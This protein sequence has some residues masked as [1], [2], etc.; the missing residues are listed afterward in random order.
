[1]NLFNHL[2]ARMRG[3]LRLHLFS[4]LFLMA[5]WLS[6]EECCC[7][8]VCGPD[9]PTCW[10]QIELDP[11]PFD[12]PFYVGA[13][14]VEIGSARFDKGELIN[15]SEELRVEQGWISWRY[16]FRLDPL[17]GVGI[18]GG[19]QRTSF[20]WRFNP[21][22]HQRHFYEWSVG[23]SGFTHRLARWEWKGFLAVYVQTEE[24][25]NFGRYGNYLG[26][27]WGRYFVCPRLG[28][29]IGGIGLVGKRHGL[30]RP[31]IGFDY[32]ILENLH[33]YAIYPVDIT[34]RCTLREF[35]DVALGCR[36][37]VNRLRFDQNAQVPQ[38]I[39]D[40]RMWGAEL[41]AEFHPFP[42]FHLD[43]FGGV[44][45]DSWLKI[46]NNVNERQVY[47]ELFSAPYGGGT[48]AIYF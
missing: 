12:A 20:Y 11:N 37:L 32:E 19:V 44:V 42:W 7:P 13:Q 10:C 2:V 18:N 31:I 9:C 25:L 6:G 24:A 28:V 38:G 30:V 40:Y 3:A 47:R 1:M 48:L 33:L 22:F 27:A 14:V 41:R 36:F 26:F 45:L 39:I 43:L 23:L 8:F 4:L 46:Y 15:P 29:H 34:L 16:L 35:L 21:F 5:G 17:T